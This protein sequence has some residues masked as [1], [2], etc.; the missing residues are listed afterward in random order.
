[1][2]KAS[3]ITI[4]LRHWL[5]GDLLMLAKAS[6]WTEVGATLVQKCIN[7]D[8]RSLSGIL[9]PVLM[10]LG[11]IAVFWHWNASLLL[12][13][14][15]G[16]SSSIVFY[17]LTQRR[18]SGRKLEQWIKSPQAPMVLSVGAG[19]GM[20]VL[21]YSALAVWQDLHSPG[22]A[23]MLFTQELGIFLA[24]GLAIWLILTQQNKPLHSFERCVAGLLHR[25]ELR[26]LMAVRQ[27]VTLMKKGQ[28][29]A[30]ERSHASDYLHLLAQREN[31]LLIRQ[32]IQ[33]GLGFLTPLQRKQLGDRTTISARR[34]KPPVAV[35]V[36]QEAMADAG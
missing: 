35:K 9:P 28:L 26:R 18:F 33:D 2:V 13:L 15:A 27:L 23:L 10:L 12:A 11:A 32:A 3:P 8:R 1:V 20:L 16:G 34:I 19:L 29:S 31:S 24:L 17:G 4:Q 21:S 7:G 36:R 22:L 5:E 6:V 25:D 30:L 14:L